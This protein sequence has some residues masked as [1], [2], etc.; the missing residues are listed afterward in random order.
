VL[1][2]TGLGRT[3]EVVLVRAR[4]DRRA[5]AAALRARCA[6][7]AV[8]TTLRTGAGRRT[9]RHPLQGCPR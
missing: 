9:V 5:A 8:T 4:L 7:A 6:E 2:L 1:E 3:T